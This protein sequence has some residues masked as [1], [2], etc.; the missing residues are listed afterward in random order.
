MGEINVLDNWCGIFPTLK[1]GETIVKM[2]G[3]I[4]IRWRDAWL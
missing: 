4:S 1:P 3:N 2:N